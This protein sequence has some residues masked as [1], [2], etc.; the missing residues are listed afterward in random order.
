MARLAERAYR[1]LSEPQRER[2]RAILLRLAD[3]EQPTPVRRRVALA[4]LEVERDEDAAGALAVL[5][6]SR[7]VT[8]DEDT[9][10][11]AHE[12]LL[13]EWPRLRGWLADDAEGRRLHQHL[14]HA[15]AEWQGSG[16]DQAELYRGARL[17]SALDWASGHE[18]ELN[19]LEREF[20]EES[21][22][23]SE[24]EAERQRRTNR[25]LRTLLAGV[26]VL[27]ALALVAGVIAL[28]E[29]QGARSA[30]TAET[31]QRLGAEA[32]TEER[33]DRALMLANTGVALDDSLATRSNLL[34]DATAQ[35]R[36]AR[37]PER[38]R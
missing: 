16:R 25:R 29:R 3:A 9:V 17:A 1:R 8:V 37:G 5:T 26:G 21:R 15:A 11:V 34:S 20:L 6:E 33:L 4:E 27:L 13:R 28:S 36:S 35:P 7:L 30:A 24:R 18:R 23:A 32:L 31:A 22:A 14:I 10:E 2:A 19:E 38:R 12:A